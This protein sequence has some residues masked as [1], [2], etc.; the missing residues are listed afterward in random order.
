MIEESSRPPSKRTS[1]KSFA[2][3]WNCSPRPDQAEGIVALEGKPQDDLEGCPP[4]QVLPQR[5]WET[6]KKGLN[7]QVNRAANL[8]TNRLASTE[9]V[10][11]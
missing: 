7:E 5:E 10:G 4:Y 11:N 3:S 1:S 9:P 6:R 8:L 2:R